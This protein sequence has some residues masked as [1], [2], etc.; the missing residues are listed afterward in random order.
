MIE[1]LR[2][3]LIRMMQVKVWRMDI[4]PTARIATT[5]LIDRTWPKGVHIGADCV[6]DNEAVVLTHDMSRGIY[7][8]TRIGPR[9]RLGARSIIMPGVSV[10]E[11]SVIAPGAV[12]IRDVP[13]RSFA[14]GNPAVVRE[15]DG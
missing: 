2:S 11:D 14:L 12:V 15:R 4:H 8:D 7:M 9:C 10:G 1:V 13:P 5:A 6:I 3:K